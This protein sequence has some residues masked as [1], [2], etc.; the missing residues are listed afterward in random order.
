VVA[1][2]TGQ[3]LNDE[4]VIVNGSG[5]QER[6]FVYVED[7]A[8]ANLLVLRNS[9]GQIYNLGSG[10]GTSVNQILNHLQEIIGYEKQPQHGPPKTGETFRIYLDAGK[11]HRELNWEPTVNLRE[12]LERT[13]AYFTALDSD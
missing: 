9:H 2:F 10:I 5:E 1:I 4:Q 13:A 7:C 3:M 8:I 12:G 6:D 11:A